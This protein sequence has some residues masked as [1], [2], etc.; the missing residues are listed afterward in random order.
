[1]ASETLANGGAADPMVQCQGSEKLVGGGARL[2]N[3]AVDTSDLHMHS[4][5]P[6]TAAGAPPAEGAT[7]TGWRAFAW[8]VAGGPNGDIEM[9]VYAI[10]AS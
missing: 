1:V 2:G 8:N 4:S 6:A 7:P 3:T 5:R 9:S 10:C